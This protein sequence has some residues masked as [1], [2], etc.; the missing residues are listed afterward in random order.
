[1]P[2]KKGSNQNG[3]APEELKVP[4]NE[5]TTTTTF[6]TTT[7]TTTTTTET[8]LNTNPQPLEM[9][10]KI[11]KKERK[12]DKHNKKRKKP[13]LEELTAKS[14]TEYQNK[15]RKKMNDTIL[16][17]YSAEKAYVGSLTAE[18]EYAEE[19]H[20]AY[21]ETK[22]ADKRKKAI[23]NRK[24]RLYKKARNKERIATAEGECEQNMKGFEAQVK[25][26]NLL[27]MESVFS[28]EQ[29]EELMKAFSAFFDLND[30]K[31]DYYRVPL[32]RM[33]RFMGLSKDLKYL[34]GEQKIALIEKRQFDVMD[35]L[36]EDLLKFDLSE[37]NLSYDG[38]FATNGVIFEQMKKKIDAYGVILRGTGDYFKSRGT[39]LKNKVEEK[40]RKMK[41]ICEYYDIRKEIMQDPHYATHYNSELTMQAGTVDEKL[42]PQ[43]YALSKKLLKSYYIGLALSNLHIGGYAGM[44]EIRP[45]THAPSQKIR[46]DVKDEVED[47]T[48]RIMKFTL[49]YDP[50]NQISAGVMKAGV[51]DQKLKKYSSFKD[52]IEAGKHLKNVAKL[53]VKQGL[54]K[55][56]DSADRIMTMNQFDAIKETNEDE[57]DEEEYDEKEID[58]NK[59]I[60]QEE[61]DLK[62]EAGSGTEG[63]GDDDEEDDEE[64]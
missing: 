5:T 30:K 4:L 44:D 45:F 23:N 53:A 29:K 8:T 24:S 63:S 31:S 21:R 15:I 47:S 2:G 3:P 33:I 42:D 49:V 51:K 60:I 22:S 41:L 11:S 64:E 17:H 7:T 59:E 54:N 20:T 43:K 62:E 27:E 39:E 6:N 34:E 18:S 1:M 61:E 38:C 14:G 40:L 13:L 12:L 52:T 19:Y 35:E 48:N 55:K 46:E 50:N 36:T 16:L 57:Y 37:I 58:D 56:L 32:N 25:K 28:K 26:R 9:N 10:F